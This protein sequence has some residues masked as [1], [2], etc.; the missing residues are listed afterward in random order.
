MDLKAYEVGEKVG[1]SD[2]SYFSTCFKRYT[3]FSIS[4]YKKV[5]GK[6]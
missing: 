6:V 5:K 1:I 3:G 4:E 2:S